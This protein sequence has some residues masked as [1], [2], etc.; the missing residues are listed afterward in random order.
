MD[1]NLFGANPVFKTDIG[2]AGQSSTRTEFGDSIIL[3]H[4]TY[5]LKLHYYAK[6][7]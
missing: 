5:V 3:D 2:W 4:S 1:L 6:W 7:S